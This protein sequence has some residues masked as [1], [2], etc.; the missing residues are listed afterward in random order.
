MSLIEAIQ[1]PMLWPYVIP[2]AAATLF[3]SFADVGAQTLCQP[4]IMQLCAPLP[5]P[6]S[7]KSTD[8]NKSDHPHG[9]SRRGLSIAPDT[10][11]GLGPGARGLGLQQRF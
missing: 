8:S 4:T 9:S 2:V 5:R 1:R 3:A 11:L 7:S 6:D 10:T